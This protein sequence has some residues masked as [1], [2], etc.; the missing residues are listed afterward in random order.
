MQQQ[1]GVKQKTK[2]P[3]LPTAPKNVDDLALLLGRVHLSTQAA[4][5]AA[6]R[7]AVLTRKFAPKIKMQLEKPIKTPSRVSY[8]P[9]RQTLNDAS[10]LRLN[11]LRLKEQEKKERETRL[12][13]LR[14]SYAFNTKKMLEAL[15]EMRIS[16]PK[17]RTV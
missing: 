8:R 1:G 16:P 13:A 6:A 10:R 4:R 15:N 11:N 14:T 7:K 12:K 9:K 5:S 3:R 2:T 17:N